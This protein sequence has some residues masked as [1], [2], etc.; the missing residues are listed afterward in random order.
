MLHSKEFVSKLG[1]DKLFRQSFKTNDSALFRYHTDK[2][3]LLQMNLQM[4]LSLKKCW[5]KIL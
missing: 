4:I 3:N 5:I 1:I 2:E